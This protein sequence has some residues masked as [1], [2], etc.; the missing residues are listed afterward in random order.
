MLNF[1]KSYASLTTRPFY[2]FD[3]LA[4][5]RAWLAAQTGTFRQLANP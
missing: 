4:E 1:L 3:S 2:V 5:A